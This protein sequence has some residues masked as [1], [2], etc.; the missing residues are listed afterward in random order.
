MPMYAF[1][2]PVCQCQEYEYRPVVRH[3]DPK[4]CPNCNALMEHDIVTQAQGTAVRG[5]YKKP[6]ELQSMGF[7]AVDEDVAEHRKR[8]PN[9][10]LVEREGSMI[11][12]VRSLGQKRAYLKA[13]GWADTKSYV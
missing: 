10:D 1:K 9:V 13:A 6:V 12:V 8:F 11:P 3:S 7:L 2:C 4:L 5:N